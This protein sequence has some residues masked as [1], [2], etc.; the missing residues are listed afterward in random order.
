MFEVYNCNL[1]VKV[2]YFVLVYESLKRAESFIAKR[3]LSLLVVI[4]YA[5]VKNSIN[6][7]F[8]SI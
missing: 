1:K 4:L 7:Q 8:L 2:K 6:A 3:I 5:F